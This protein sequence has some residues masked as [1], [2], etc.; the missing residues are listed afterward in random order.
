M[1]RWV[2]ITCSLLVPGHAADLACTSSINLACARR[3]REDMKAEC[4]T[5]N[6]T[7][8][9]GRLTYA[10]G[11]EEGYLAGKE[12]ARSKKL[13][14]S[15]YAVSIVVDLVLL[16][17]VLVSFARLERMFYAPKQEKVVW[18]H[19]AAT[20][21][22]FGAEAA[23]P[24]FWQKAW[25]KVFPSRSGAF[26]PRNVSEAYEAARQHQRQTS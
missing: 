5:G 22:F 24:G 19:G 7:A 23:E 10:S 1:A 26:I 3:G 12:A 21:N 6:F 13:T 9:E 8:Q 20:M 2:A 18:G 4:L 11:F 17:V 14:W 15:Q 25:E 16:W